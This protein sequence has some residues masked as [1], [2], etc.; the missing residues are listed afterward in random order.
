[1]AVITLPY[2]YLEELTGV[3]KDV[4]IERL[5]MI[6]ADIERYEDDHFDVEFFPDR[7]DMFSTEG[8][9]R[10]MRGFLNI[11]R[12]WWLCRVLNLKIYR[13]LEVTIWL[14]TRPVSFS[15]NILI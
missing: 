2:K 15:A 11:N 6:A 3:S 10:A 1:M 5:P 12:T 8:V 13:R 4:L 14:S 9:A 7:P